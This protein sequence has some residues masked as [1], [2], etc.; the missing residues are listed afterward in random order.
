MIRL[1]LCLGI[2]PAFIPKNQPQLNA[3]PENFTGWFQPRLFDRHYARQ[4]DQRRESTRRHEVVTTPH[5]LPR[6]GVRTP[7]QCRR[8]LRLCELPASFVVPTERLPLTACYVTFIRRVNTAG[9]VYV[10]S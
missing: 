3:R 10:P 4:S 5:V 9:T 2:R 7:V 1:C 6:L 8:G